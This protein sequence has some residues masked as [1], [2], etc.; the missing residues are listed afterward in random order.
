MVSGYEAIYHW[1]WF[2]GTMRVSEYAP[3]SSCLF[4]RKHLFSLKIKIQSPVL[5]I[6]VSSSHFPCKQPTQKRKKE[7]GKKKIIQTNK[8]KKKGKINKWSCWLRLI[9]EIS[10]AISLTELLLV[11]KQSLFPFFFFP[12]M[13]IIPRYHISTHKDEIPN[14][15]R[16]EKQN[17]KGK[18]RNWW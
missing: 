17:K 10:N 4:P 11:S 13:N 3:L 8:E 15:I 2:H 18:L 6:T 16:K 9:I 12:K 14:P 7:S 1:K 5:R